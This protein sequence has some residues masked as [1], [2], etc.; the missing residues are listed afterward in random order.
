MKRIILTLTLVLFVIPFGISQV[1]INGNT[2]ISGSL[3][4]TNINLPILSQIEI[5]VLSPEIGDIVYNSTTRKLQIYS[6]PNAETETIRF[7][8][9]GTSTSSELNFDFGLMKK[10]KI[11]GSPRDINVLN[12]NGLG[13]TG[14]SSGDSVDY[15]GDAS[16]D[17]D[18]ESITFE[19]I[20][21]DFFDD[22]GVFNIRVSIPSQ[23]QS[24]PYNGA[25]GER[26]ITVYD[27]GGNLIGDYPMYDSSRT[28]VTI[29]FIDGE[30]DSS[31]KLISKFTLRA[32]SS[33]NFRIGSITFDHYEDAS[34]NAEWVDLN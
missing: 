9:I 18:D 24:A 11:T 4:A 32:L 22:Y 1:L 20:D 6:Y 33:D 26:Q 3:T 2:N 8:D 19:F 7:D 31:G 17:S 21:E 12:F 25:V 16:T 23:G 15:G 5:D 34:T 29:D 27:L 30:G 13:I 28:P 10:L 14:G